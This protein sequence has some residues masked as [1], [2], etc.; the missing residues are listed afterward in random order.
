[1]SVY[2]FQHLKD[3]KKFAFFLS[4]LSEIVGVSAKGTIG[5]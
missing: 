5:A 4:P 2:D 3:L 1:M